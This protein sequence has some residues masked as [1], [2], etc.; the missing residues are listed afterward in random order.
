MS[1]EP[2]SIRLPY[3]LLHGRY[4]PIVLIRLFR[5]SKQI[6]DFALV[7]SGA[8]YSI[9]DASIASRLGIDFKLGRRASVWGLEG[10]LVP[11]YLHP[12]G[13]TIGEF[14]LTTEIGFSEHLR[15]GFNLLGRHLIFNQ[16]QFCFNDRDSELIVSRL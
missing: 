13:L 6:E 3:R 8:I 14:H 9:F 4:A 5:D 16:L 1:N 12:L 2:N 11:I 7:D 15:V 10:R